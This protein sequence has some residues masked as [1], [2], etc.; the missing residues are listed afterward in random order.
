MAASYTVLPL[1]DDARQ[2]LSK[3]RIEVRDEWAP[4]R[5]PTLAELRTA[6]D[7]LPGCQV[8][9]KISPGTWQATVSRQDGSWASLVVLDYDPV[10]HSE[11]KPQRFYFEKGSEDLIHTI[12]RS[13]AEP[14]GS[15]VVFSNA[16][17]S[18][19]VMVPAETP[20]SGKT[21]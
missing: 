11:G 17:M 12:V 18:P 21:W 1:D 10:S 4:G 15:L 9:Y 14:C 20:T 13:L 5:Y 8:E 7:G 3:K 19:K 16:D 6:L 2:W